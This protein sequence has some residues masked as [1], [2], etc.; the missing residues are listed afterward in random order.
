[1]GQ[2]TGTVRITLL[3]T[4]HSILFLLHLTGFQILPWPRQEKINSDMSVLV[5]TRTRW[6]KHRTW[7]CKSSLLGVVLPHKTCWFYLTKTSPL[8]SGICLWPSEQI[9]QSCSQ[10]QD[11]SSPGKATHMPCAPQLHIPALEWW[12]LS[13]CRFS[14]NWAN[15]CLFKHSGLNSPLHFLGWSSNPTPGVMGHN[16]WCNSHP[17]TTDVFINSFKLKGV[18]GGFKSTPVPCCKH[19]TS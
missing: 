16:P 13:F 8:C 19:H 15:L 17:S 12:H 14:K 7:A 6:C 3:V 11:S 1:M 2:G 5:W 9:P 10:G 4:H 18:F